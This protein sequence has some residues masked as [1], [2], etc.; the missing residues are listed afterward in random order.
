VTLRWDE[1]DGQVTLK[2]GNAVLLTSSSRRSFIDSKVKPDRRYA[3]SIVVVDSSGQSSVPQTLRVK[4]HPPPPTVASGVYGGTCTDIAHSPN[5]PGVQDVER[6]RQWH[7]TVVS[8]NRLKLF[9]ASGGYSL[10]LS[11]V[12]DSKFFGSGSIGGG[13]ERAINL[14]LKDPDHEGTASSLESINYDRYSS[15]SVSLFDK[16]SCEMKHR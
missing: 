12:G 7:F 1:S 13:W 4:T 3:Y 10:V 8:A 16:V 5:L 6:N 11:R 2:R 14:L 15:G 9:S